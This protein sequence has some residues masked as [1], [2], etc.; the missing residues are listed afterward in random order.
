VGAG[1]AR[2]SGKRE[3]DDPAKL[4]RFAQRLQ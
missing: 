4:R 1:E 3:A 2:G